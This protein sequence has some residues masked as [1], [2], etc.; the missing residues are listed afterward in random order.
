[1]LVFAAQPLSAI[2]LYYLIKKGS[3]AYVARRIARQFQ[4]VVVKKLL[5]LH[6]ARQSR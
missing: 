1:M 6:A 3:K 2:V 5:R 4:I